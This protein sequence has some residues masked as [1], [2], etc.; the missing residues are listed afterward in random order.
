MCTRNIPRLVLSEL[1]CGVGHL[2]W[3]LGVSRLTVNLLLLQV[4]LR[5]DG[6]L[7]HQGLIS[8]WNT[9]ITGGEQLRLLLDILGRVIGRIE[10]LFNV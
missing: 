9:S 5:F 3:L 10:Y 2:G 1:A 8:G 4:L 6:L 7:G